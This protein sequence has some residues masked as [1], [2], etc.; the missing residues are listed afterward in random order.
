[1]FA[2]RKFLTAG[3]F[4]SFFI[5]GFMDN[6]KGP[7][8]PEILRAETLNYSQGGTIVLSG[9]LGFIAATLLTGVMADWLGSRGVLLSAGLSLLLGVAALSFSGANFGAILASMGMIG[10]GLGA[11]EVGGNSLMVELYTVNRARYL[12]LLATCHGVG[13]LLV[14]LYAATLV[15]WEFSWQDIYGCSLGLVVILPTIFCLSQ[16]SSHTP[17]EPD[18]KAPSGTAAGRWSWQETL[19]IGFSPRMGWYYVLLASYVAVELGLAAWLVE[20][21]HQNRD[22]TV[23]H[24]SLYL[25]GF[26]VMLMLGRLLG[27]FAVERIGYFRMVGLALGGGSLCIAA[28]LFGSDRW[29]GALPLSGFFLSIVFPTVTASVSKLYQ[30]NIGSL[31][32]LLFTAA[33]I[34]GALGSWSVGVIGNSQGLQAGMAV[35][36]AYCLLGLLAL[37]V[38]SRWRGD[39]PAA[40]PV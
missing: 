5:F 4:F 17:S 15:T 6:L 18:S 29:I 21:L 28:G 39:S 27:S 12:N 23:A 19:R 31:L 11:I 10:F 14:P 24:A 38:L 34:G 32:G 26:F 33:G 25:S 7:L 16:L 35:T 3:G 9:Y 22:M 30:Q 20:Y 1:M 36:L 8:L 2:S 37:Y 40:E 13:S